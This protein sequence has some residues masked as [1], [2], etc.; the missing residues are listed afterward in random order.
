M[1][2][3][4]IIERQDKQLVSARELYNFLELE[5]SNFSRWLKKNITNNDF[6]IEDEDYVKTDTNVSKDTFSGLVIKDEVNTDLVDFYL[7]LDSAKKL[8]ML[9]RSKKGEQVRQ[10]F[11]NCEKVAKKIL[12]QKTNIAWQEARKLTKDNYAPM[13]EALRLQREEEGKETKPFHYSNEASLI[14]KVLTGLTPKKYRELYAVGAVREAL[15]KEELVW[16]NRLQSMNTG[17]IAIGQD[18]NERK[19]FLT[20][21][22]IKHKDRLKIVRGGE[23]LALIEAS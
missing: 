17:L 14:C 6:L 10:Y 11:L 5:K 2:L 15:T 12:Q 19:S 23:Q 21:Y 9:S 22:Y 18:Y 13:S 1:E 20:Q 3:L 4:K 16:L 8:A 7:T